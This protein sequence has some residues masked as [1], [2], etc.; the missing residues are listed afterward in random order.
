MC[1]GIMVCT[2]NWKVLGLIPM[3]AQPGLVSN[4]II[5]LK[6]TSRLKKRSFIFS[7]QT[8]C[9]SLVFSLQLHRL[10][11]RSMSY[12]KVM[13]QKQ[14]L[15]LKNIIVWQMFMFANVHRFKKLYRYV[16]QYFHLKLVKNCVSVWNL[17]F[18]SYK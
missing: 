3:D 7:Q 11:R 10:N 17:K 15:E 4:L 8:L 14:K 5:R 1:I 13:L 12:K 18:H 2:W 6:V 16:K 9:K